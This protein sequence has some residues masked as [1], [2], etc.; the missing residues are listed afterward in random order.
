MCAAGKLWPFPF[1]LVYLFYSHFC[2]ILQLGKVTRGP[3][4]LPYYADIMPLSTPF[5]L[6]SGTETLLVAKLVAL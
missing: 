6:I 1:L 4:Q 5:E 2:S 3:T